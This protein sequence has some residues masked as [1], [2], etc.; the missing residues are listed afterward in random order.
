MN[1]VIQV[2]INAKDTKEF[3]IKDLKNKSRSHL[4]IT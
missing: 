4:L 1:I 3:K 2:S